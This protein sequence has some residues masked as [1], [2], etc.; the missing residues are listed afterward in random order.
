AALKGSREIGFTIISMTLSLAA[1]F[2]PILFMGGILG[3][4]LH[5]FAVTIAT[6]VL[7]SGF[8]SLTLTPMLTSRFVRSAHSRKHNRIYD[9]SERFFDGILKLYDRTL[10][11][12]LRHRFAML[13]FSFAVLIAT[14]FMFVKIPKG[15][16][17][18]EDTGRIS[19][20]TE[21][22]QDIS[23]DAMLQHQKEIAKIIADDPNVADFMSAIG[24]SGRT[25]TANSGRLFMRLKPRSERKLSAEQVIEELRP[26]L[27]KVPGIQTYLQVPPLIRIGGKVTKG[28]YQ[29]SLQDTDLNELYKWSPILVDKLSQLP[30]FED[31][32]SDL[33]IKNPQIT[34][35][36]DRNKASA[37][38]V[39]PEQIE[40]A[41]Y[42]AYGQR[43][44]S[45]IYTDV[46][47]YWVVMEAEPKFQRDPAA[48]AGLYI[49]SFNGQLVPLGAVAKL[50]RSIGPM[51]ITHDGQLPSVTISFNLAPGVSLGTAVDEVQRVQEELHMPATISASFQ[52]S[53]QVFQSSLKGLGLLLV[54]AILV[55]YIILGILYES[56]IHPITI[57]SG[58]PSAGF[59][60][61]L[62]LMIF[63][64]DL[65]IYAFVGLIMLV[66]IVKKNAIMMI[67]FA[68]DAE[69]QG[70]SPRDAI[71]QGCL[72]R[73]R[74]IMMTTAAALMGTLPIAIG[75]G[76]GG[77]SRRP[78][79]LAVV[80]GLIV[81]QLLTLYSTPV[82]YLYLESFLQWTRRHMPHRRPAGGESSAPAP[83][84]T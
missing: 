84:V 71:Y 3:R 81:S 27:A 53:A 31:V 34:V 30:G 15:F 32:T 66:G 80:G 13:C 19:A 64:M 9:A 4:L 76:A 1:V 57:L 60:A 29:F 69:R 12:V 55:I 72:L 8:V 45:T 46:N 75:L 6:A 74:P 7:V 62:T 20:T 21:A 73:F 49:R 23:Y 35:E 24:A 5:E 65:N 63:G 77:E 50:S 67:D 44:I 61:L 83:A 40:S 22:A 17:P 11:I 82:I 25:P 59:G 52:G 18:V 28:L 48:L 54:M 38:G 58:L 47:E 43:Q 14:A 2:I 70:K 56:F 79:G 42:D 36:I 16:F 26:K 41:L 39:T 10:Q 51:T 37:V 33:L 68:L 78:L